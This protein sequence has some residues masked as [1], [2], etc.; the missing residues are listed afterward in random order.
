MLNTRSVS[1]IN[2]AR[3]SAPWFRKLAARNQADAFGWLPGCRNIKKLGSAWLGFH[4]QPERNGREEANI[5]GKF[6]KLCICNAW[7]AGD[8]TF[9]YTCVRVCVRVRANGSVKRLGLRRETGRLVQ[10]C[11]QRTRVPVSPLDA[12]L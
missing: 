2:Y 4:R 12:D 9:V 6:M 3:H 5:A 11:R 7:S 1:D 8:R 10:T